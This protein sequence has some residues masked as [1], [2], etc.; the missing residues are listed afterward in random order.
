MLF[1]CEANRNESTRRNKNV[2]S[3][4]Y[5]VMKALISPTLD[6]HKDEQSDDLKV[7]HERNKMNMKRNIVAWL[8][9]TQE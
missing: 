1:M 4:L 3:L 6:R 7:V 8:Q 2:F 5:Y 9:V